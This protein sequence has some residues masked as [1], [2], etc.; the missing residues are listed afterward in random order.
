MRRHEE[1]RMPR[2][3]SILAL[4]LCSGFAA[5]GDWPQWL[6]PNRDGG[7]TEKVA[8]WKAPPLLLW[9]QPVGEGHS[10]PVV[11]GSRV[12]LH[13]KVK[14]KD[15]EEVVAFD[16][17]TGKDVWRSRYE[18]GAFSSPFGVGPRA[19]PIVADGRIY[20]YGVTG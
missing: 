17:G 3:T 6:G 5:A 4:I 2:L 18:R 16:A 13:V 19:T 7:S 20:T 10:S 14:D 11:A 12:Y 8:P 15:E 9:R 1:N